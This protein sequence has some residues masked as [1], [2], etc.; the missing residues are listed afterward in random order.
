MAAGTAT[1]AGGEV[2]V[3]FDVIVRTQGRRPGALAEAMAS[4]GAQ[5]T[6]CDFEVTVAVHGSALTASAVEAALQQ[7][8]SL[9][10]RWSVLAVTDGGGRARPLNAA[11]KR[12]GGDYVA[13]LDDDDLVYP[14]W[15]AAF[16]EGAAD[17]PGRVIRAAADVQD[18]TAS[19]TGEPTAAAGRV[20]RPYADRFDLL[21]HLA[22]N[23][24]PI[25]SIA[26]PREAM[27]KSGLSFD[28][29]LEVLEDWD[30]LMRTALR[31]G[32]H[33]IPA[34]TSLVRRLDA[35]SATADTDER[36]W[37]TSREQVLRKLEAKPF[38]VPGA[39]VRRLADA[40]FTPGGPPVS[41]LADRPLP[42]Q[43]RTREFKRYHAQTRCRVTAVLGRPVSAALRSLARRALPRA[44][45]AQA[46]RILRVAGTGRTPG[47]ADDRI[48]EIRP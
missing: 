24:T 7:T 48:P 41:A 21:A 44:V 1:T 20:T 30:L 38:S 19:Q 29:D 11:L 33:S 45:R 22:H 9:P 46:R 28:E 12:A 27:Q 2:A 23:E 3:S 37:L 31:T 43:W 26:L 34:T 40:R 32:V 39:D 15:L 18:W 17:A 8:E 16:A 47:R 14:H 25:C 6:E 10:E 36:Q 42:L 5:Q 35:G 4:L 13:F